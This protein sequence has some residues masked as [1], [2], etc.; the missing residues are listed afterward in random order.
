MNQEDRMLELKDKREQL[1]YI[2]KDILK[3][4][5]NKTQESNIQ[6]ILYVSPLKD[7]TFEL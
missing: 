4:L 5:K 1:D 7:R 3:N 2:S 6:D